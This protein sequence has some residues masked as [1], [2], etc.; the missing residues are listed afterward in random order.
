M[1][2]SRFVLESEIKKMFYVVLKI[3]IVKTTKSKEL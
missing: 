3:G 1:S 2:T